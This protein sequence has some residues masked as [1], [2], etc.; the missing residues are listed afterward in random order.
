MPEFIRLSD[1][2][3]NLS[4]VREMT[5]PNGTVVIHWQNG[6]KRILTGVDV[7]LFLR[8]LDKRYDLMTDPAALFWN[9]EEDVEEEVIA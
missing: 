1:S 2:I 4:Q 5:F 7:D 3:V 8:G 6:E 9:V